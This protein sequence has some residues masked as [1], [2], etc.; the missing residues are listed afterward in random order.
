MLKSACSLYTFIAYRKSTKSFWATFA[1]LAA[2]LLVFAHCT[3]IKQLLESPHQ[4]QRAL[5]FPV[6]LWLL[7]CSHRVQL[8][9]ME[10]ETHLRAWLC[11]I[12]LGHLWVLLMQEHL[13]GVLEEDNMP[14]ILTYTSA[15]GRE[16][17]V[18]GLSLVCYRFPCLGSSFPLPE[19]SVNSIFH[20]GGVMKQE[21]KSK[22]CW[23]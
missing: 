23:L 11:V 22:Q 20:S 8:L 9:G 19:F 13:G 4:R 5:K 17:C 15:S 6:Q 3:L 21:D 16:L 2:L 18:P 10:P 14:G 1:V 12:T 7:P